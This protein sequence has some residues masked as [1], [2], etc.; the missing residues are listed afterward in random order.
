[1]RSGASLGMCEHYHRGWRKEHVDN[2]ASLIRAAMSRVLRAQ[3]SL[4]DLEIR[5]STEFVWDRD[6]P[7]LELKGLFYCM[8][9]RPT[10]ETLCKS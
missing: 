6:V 7:T 4:K 10:V 8:E 3:T 9:D 5:L 1:M 2:Y